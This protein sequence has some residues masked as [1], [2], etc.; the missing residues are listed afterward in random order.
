MFEKDQR[1][2]FSGNRLS[3]HPFRPRGRSVDTVKAIRLCHASGRWR[4][5]TRRRTRLLSDAAIGE[6]LVS[7]CP[8]PA[9]RDASWRWP[10]SLE[11]R[12]LID[13]PVR[14]QRQTVI[15]GSKK[16]EA[17]HQ[18]TKTRAGPSPRAS[19]CSFCS[20][21]SPVLWHSPKRKPP[22]RRS[23]AW[24]ATVRRSTPSPANLETIAAAS[25]TPSVTVAPRTWP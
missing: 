14:P 6:A 1:C 16:D 18:R 9:H 10:N 23:A 3:D 21:Y 15:F 8:H 7:V 5:R 17:P 20:Q 11:A 19:A 4:H 13:R 2:P 25:S 22:L 12:G 24:S